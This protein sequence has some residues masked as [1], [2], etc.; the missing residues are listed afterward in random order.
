LANDT[1]DAEAICEAVTRPTMRFVEVKT[2]EQ[3]SIMVVH[4]ARTMLMRQRG[5][6]SNAIRGH[7]AEFGLVAPVGREGL[8]TLIYT[9]H[10]AMDDRVPANFTARFLADGL[11]LGTHSS[12]VEI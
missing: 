8:L 11:Q 7:M 1:A 2:P 10:E 6:L 4:G 9:L 5:Q 3:Q 12:V